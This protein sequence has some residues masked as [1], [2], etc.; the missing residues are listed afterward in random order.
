MVAHYCISILIITWGPID[1]GLSLVSVRAAQS[2]YRSRVLFFT[3]TT[4]TLPRDTKY[5]TQLPWSGEENTVYQ[6]RSS[7]SYKNISLPQNKMRRPIDDPTPLRSCRLCWRSATGTPPTIQTLSPLPRRRSPAIWLRIEII[8]LC[9][10]TLLLEF[11][12]IHWGIFSSDPPPI[13]FRRKTNCHSMD[14]GFCK[15][16]STVVGVGVCLVCIGRD[17]VLGLLGW[18][19]GGTWSSVALALVSS[20][21]ECWTSYLLLWVYCLSFWLSLGD[22]QLGFSVVDKSHCHNII[23]SRS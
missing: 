16:C 7:S 2:F 8:I 9:P 3:S 12:I 5:T 10:L 20:P 13:L 15:N 11:T 22:L 23:S 21:L 6:F 14:L 17:L 19:E 18:M 4:N 1:R